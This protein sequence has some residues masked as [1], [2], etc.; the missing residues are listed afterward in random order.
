MRRSRSILQL[1]HNQIGPL[2][3][4]T[5]S[6]DTWLNT[7][8]SLATSS[9]FHPKLPS[10]PSKTPLSFSLLISRTD[11]AFWAVIKRFHH[12][13]M[14]TIVKNKLALKETKTTVFSNVLLHKYYIAHS[15]FWKHAYWK[16]PHAL[17]KQ[18]YEL[19]QAGLFLGSSTIRL[20]FS[21][22]LGVSPS[23]IRTVSVAGA[24]SG[25]PSV[26][27]ICWRIRVVS[28]QTLA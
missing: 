20:S 17:L 1:S 14:A 9:P 27:M 22:S 16:I 28:L 24:L 13:S 4:I 10:P 19:N 2:G 26:E 11:K 3:N 6:S 21:V 25:P 8:I 5:G 18:Y 7:L 15:T 12:S 23:Y